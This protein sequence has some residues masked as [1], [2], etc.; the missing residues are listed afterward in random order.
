[1]T[2]TTHVCPHCGKT[3]EAAI[4]INGVAAVE[5][6]QNIESRKRMYSKL[7]LDALERLKV[8]DSIPYTAARKMILDALNDFARDIHTIMGFGTEVE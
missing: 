7:T 2:T 5:A 3:F 6:A 1:M 4:K 8:S